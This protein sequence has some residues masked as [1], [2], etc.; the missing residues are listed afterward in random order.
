[1]AEFER[2]HFAGEDRKDHRPYWKRAHHDW[3]FWVGVVCMFVA[4]TCYV[5]RDQAVFLPH[6]QPD[7]PPSQS[8]ATP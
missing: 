4:I 3:R 5:F 7:K 1:M 6:S 8:S 2:M